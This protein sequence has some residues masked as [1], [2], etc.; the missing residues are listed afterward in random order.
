MTISINSKPATNA[1]SVLLHFWY[2]NP[3]KAVLKEILLM[4][5]LWMS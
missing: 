1:Y 5:S 4:D 3:E 2:L